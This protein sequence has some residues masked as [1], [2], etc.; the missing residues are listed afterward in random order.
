MF[1]RCAAIMLHGG[2]VSV[3]KMLNGVDSIGVFQNLIEVKD[4]Q[5]DPPHMLIGPR[6]LTM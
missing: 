3:C 1:P 2:M 6:A 4:H 5:L